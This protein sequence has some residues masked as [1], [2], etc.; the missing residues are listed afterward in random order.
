MAQPLLS[1][2]DLTVS[3]PSEQGPHEAVKEVSLDLGRGASLGIVGESGS[4]KSLTALSILNLLPS[5][6]RVDGGSIRY[7]PEEAPPVDILQAGPRQ[8]RSIRGR[9][10]SMIFQEP[11]TSLN[12]VHTCGEQVCEIML[13]H[14]DYSRKEAKDKAIEW[15]REVELPNPGRIFSSYPHELSGGQRQR[16]MI[17]MAISCEPRLL[18]A[19]E[20]TT[21]L[22]VTIQKSILRLLQKLRERYRMSLIFISHDLGVVSSVADKVAVMYQGRIV[23]QGLQQ[24]VIHAPAHDYTRGLIACRPPVDHKPERLYTLRDFTQKPGPG[25]EPVS[26]QVKGSAPRDRGDGS[27][28]FELKDLSKYFALETNFFGRPVQ[29]LQALDGVNLGIQQGQT[30]GLVGESGSGKS[31]MARILLHLIRPDEGGLFYKGKDVMAFGKKEMRSFRQ[32][33]QIVFQDPYSTLNP[34]LSVGQMIGEPLAYYRY[35]SRR[36]ER[37]ERVI[38]ILEN[39]RLGAGFYRRYPHELSGGQRQR[40][41]IARVL[42][43]NPEFVILDEAVSALDV[44]I[45]AEILNLLQELKRQYNLTYVF[46]THD[47]S[48]VRFMSDTIAV[49]KEGRIIE[50]GD[51]EQLF[52][53][54]A[55]GYTQKLLESIPSL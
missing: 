40:V 27:T 8:I 36:K 52:R 4:G 3:F 32:Q 35:V 21:A 14:M 51:S 43:L 42:A 7:F 33:V 23:E 1:I 49:M 31:T 22:D 29:R 6:S 55:S 24:Q 20:P 19:D 17:A 30:M 37:K 45:Q 2:R 44:S 26:Q 48:V 16:V 5:A 28:I 18:I 9:H 54:P 50:T 39:V 47:F 13:N 25:P 46:I 10:I 38:E 15:F 12:P 11:M 53:S 34:R 41:A